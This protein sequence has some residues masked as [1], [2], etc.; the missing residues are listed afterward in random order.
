MSTSL[1]Q[2]HCPC[3]SQR[4]WQVTKVSAKLAK[5]SPY[6]SPFEVANKGNEELV[7]I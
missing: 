6:A 3:L 1:S 5:T 7:I 2:C 4:D